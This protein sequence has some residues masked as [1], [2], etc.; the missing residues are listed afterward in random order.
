MSFSTGTCSQVLPRK[1]QLD[2]LVHDAA[3]A[4]KKY[5]RERK[6]NLNITVGKGKI[7]CHTSILWFPLLRLQKC[8]TVDGRSPQQP[9]GM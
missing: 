3:I 6:W 7:I 9:P 5:P 8:N 1:Q 2:D 4:R